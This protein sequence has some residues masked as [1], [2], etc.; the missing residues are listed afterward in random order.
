MMNFI[1]S[2]NTNDMLLI[3]FL[4]R[5]YTDTDI[6]RPII[7]I[8]ESINIIMFTT[9]IV[10]HTEKIIHSVLLNIKYNLVIFENHIDFG[11]IWS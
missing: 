1:L 11:C 4:R 5:A 8:I 2:E 7:N 3:K 10:Y 9:W 6:F